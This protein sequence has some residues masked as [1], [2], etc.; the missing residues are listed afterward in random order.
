MFSFLIRPNRFFLICE[1]AALFGIVPL[2][3]GL[4]P[5]RLNVHL[6]LWL[7]AAYAASILH[8]TPDFSWHE[9]WRGLSLKSRDYKI[10]LARFCVSTLGIILLTQMIAPERLFSFPIQRPIFW[11]VVM[12]L[13]PVLSALPQEMV[14]RTFFFRRYASLFPKEGVMLTIS[15][16]LF[17]FIHVVFH[18]PVSPLLSLFC[19][20]FLAG[21]YLAHRSLQKAALEHA[22]Y[23]DMV[24]TVGLGFYFLVQAT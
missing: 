10:I 19:G 1:C 16:I 18:N 3:I 9:A 2:L 22:L 6:S 17:G 8:H 15:A 11:L 4:H 24:F 7:I 23:G 12:I 20:F 21:S 14:F 5:T 13:Y